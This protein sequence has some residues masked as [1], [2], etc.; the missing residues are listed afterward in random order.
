MIKK[1][2]NSALRRI[3]AAKEWGHRCRDQVYAL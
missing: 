2:E 1:Q 3:S